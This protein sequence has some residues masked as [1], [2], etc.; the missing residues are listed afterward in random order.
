MSIY[1]EDDEDFIADIE[2]KY[3]VKNSIYSEG[4]LLRPKESLL[5]EGAFI[6]I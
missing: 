4:K 3:I 5:I 2:N 6:S 1:E